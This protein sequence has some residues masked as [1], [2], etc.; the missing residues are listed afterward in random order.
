VK[1]YFLRNAASKVSWISMMTMNID[2]KVT[3]STRAPS[4]NLVTPFTKPEPIEAAQ[5]SRDSL[6]C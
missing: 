5:V 2:L 4:E 6:I 3:L 1:V